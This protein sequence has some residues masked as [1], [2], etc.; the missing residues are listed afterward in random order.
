VRSALR[1]LGRVVCW[2]LAVCGTFATVVFGVVLVS[3]EDSDERI[4]AV[5]LL[6]AALIVLGGAIAGLRAIPGPV[7]P[8]RPRTS[9]PRHAAS[10]ARASRSSCGR[11]RGR[12]WAFVLCLVFTGVAVV[13][14]ADRWAS[15]Q[16]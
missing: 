7:K 12:A 6:V 11:A 1:I 15:E 16:L 9:S 2:V 4:G 13:M 5:A 3:A 8:P 14:V 10:C